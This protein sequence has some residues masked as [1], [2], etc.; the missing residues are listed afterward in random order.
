MKRS[1]VGRSSRIIDVASLVLV[2][3]G[4]LLYL[5]AY[6]RMEA[7]RTRPHEEFIPFVTE[8]WARTREHARLTRT[9]QI[10]LA[11]CG[12]SVIVG[13]SAAAHAYIIARRKEN[14]PS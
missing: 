6:V 14:V 7:L 13:L 8:A 2:C 3:L 4:G 11:L 1:D 5:F 9:S 10:G 12:A